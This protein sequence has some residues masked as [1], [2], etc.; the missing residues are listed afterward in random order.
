M[1]VKD[2][3]GEYTIIGTNQNNSDNNYKGTLTLTVDE[4]NRVK[5]K[6]LIHNEQKQI[7][8]GFFKDN[9]LVINFKYRG[10]E[11]EIFSGVVVYKCLSKDTLDGFW[12]EDLGDPNYLGQEQCFRVGS[13]TNI[14]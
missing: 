6:W 3:E 2:I 9:I 4:Y 7:G 8:Y 13:N 12:S 1:T 11:D 14:N 5:A 10:N